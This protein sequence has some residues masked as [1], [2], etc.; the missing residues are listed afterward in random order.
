MLT[1]VDLTMGA[2]EEGKGDVDLDLDH[3]LW[4]SHTNP[5]VENHER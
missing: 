2:K 4:E 1:F 3:D 5:V